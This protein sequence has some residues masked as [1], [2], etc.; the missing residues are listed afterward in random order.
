MISAE[1]AANAGSGCDSK[2]FISKEAAL[3]VATLHGFQQGLHPWRVVLYFSWSDRR[4][5]WSVSN[6]LEEGGSYGTRGEDLSID[7]VTAK[8]LNVGTHAA[9][10]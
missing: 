4:V 1:C 8:V 6:V 3:C 7:A 2:T 10:P 9:V 5:V